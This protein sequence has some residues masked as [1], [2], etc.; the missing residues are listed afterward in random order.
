MVLPLQ[1]DWAGFVRRLFS[2]E[3][4]FAFSLAILAVGLIVAYLVWRWTARSLGQGW[5]ADAAEGTPIDRTAQSIGSSTVG[6]I[7]L[8]VGVFVYVLAIVLAL[9]VAQLLDIQLFWT[10]LTGYLPRLFVAALAIIVGLV[11]GDKAEV[12]VDERLRSVKLPEVTFVGDIVKY[13]IFYVAALVAL[14][15]IGVATVALLILLGAYAFGLV[16]LCG[17]AF[18]HLLAASAAG[19]YL[20]LTQPYAIGDEIRIDERRGIVQE[21]DMFVT[22]IESGGEEYIIPNQE[23][24]RSGIVRVRE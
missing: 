16:F 21:V 9:N 8:L 15:Q 19:I 18:R 22:R 17:L 7:A 12:V 24:F 1:T 13:S 20:L 10:R 6:I 4:A 2:R 14:A 11:A 23:V 3:A 5:F